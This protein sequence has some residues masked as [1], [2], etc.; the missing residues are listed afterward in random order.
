G[1]LPTAQSC[2][3]SIHYLGQTQP[4][5]VLL[6]D[7]GSATGTLAASLQG[8]ANTV[9]RTDIGVGHSAPDTLAQV[10]ADAVR[11]WLPFYAADE[12]LQ[13]Y[14]LNKALRPGG[15]PETLRE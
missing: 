11:R 8:R 7:V 4:G 9:I 2:G 15:V 13:A 1:I 3:L 14:A 10:G 12:D 6:I 5:G